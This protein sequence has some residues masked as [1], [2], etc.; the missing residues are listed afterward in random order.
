MFIG[1]I[2][3][4]L[5]LPFCDL[6]VLSTSTATSIV[7]NTVLSVYY[8]GERFDWRLDGPAFVLII[9]G[10]LAIVFLSDYSDTSYTPDVIRDLIFSQTMAIFMSIY[11]VVIIVTI[12]EY[13]WHKRQIRKF[14]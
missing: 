6:V 4:V 2:L 13:I 12:V 8:L 1:S 10:S 14:N 5:V 3:H 11:L 7:F 9:G